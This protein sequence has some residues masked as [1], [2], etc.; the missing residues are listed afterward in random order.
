MAQRA[1]SGCKSS[2]VCARKTS[3]TNSLQKINANDLLEAVR[4]PCP[5]ELS[6]PREVE[7]RHRPGFLLGPPQHIQMHLLRPEKAALRP[8]TMELLLLSKM[9]I[10]TIMKTKGTKT[11]RRNVLGLAAQNQHAQQTLLKADGMIMLPWK[12]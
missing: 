4:V 7:V 1:V 8:V 3:G 5:E 11:I 10:K 9:R 12:H 2:K 6:S